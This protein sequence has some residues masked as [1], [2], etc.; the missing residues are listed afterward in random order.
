MLRPNLDKSALIL[1][2]CNLEFN[3]NRLSNVFYIFLRTNLKNE[4]LYYWDGDLNFVE[5]TS[6]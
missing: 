4:I 2:K 3:L 6:T 5:S 1:L